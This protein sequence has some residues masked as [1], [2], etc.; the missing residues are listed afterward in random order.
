MN[1]ESTDKFCEEN[2]QGNWNNESGG[3]PTT[4][5]HSLLYDDLGE[6][7]ATHVNSNMGFQTIDSTREVEG[8]AG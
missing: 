6:P 4:R 7:S 3:G 8:N 5:N 2:Y 1:N